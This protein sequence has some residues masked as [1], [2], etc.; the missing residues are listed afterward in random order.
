MR[1][2]RAILIEGGAT[3]SLAAS[4][5]L[6][7]NPARAAIQPPDFPFPGGNGQ[8]PLTKDF[9]Q[10]G[11]MVLQRSR[12]PLLE[13][14]FADFDQDV[15]TPNDKFFVRWHWSDIPTDIDAKS[16]RL[17]VRGQVEHELS[18]SLPDLLQFKPVEIAAVNQCSGNSR[19]FFEPRVPG[20]QWGNGAMGNAR[21]TGV[22]LKDVLDKAG[23]KAGAVAVRFGGLDK[24][25]VDDAPPFKKS[26]SIDHA[27]QPEILIAYAMN[28]RALPLLNGY[29]IRLVVPGWYSTYWIKMLSDIEVLDGPDDNYWM[30]TAYLIPDTPHADI[31]PG[32]AG[33]AMVPINRMSSR[34]FITNLSPGARLKAGARAKLRGLAMG[35]DSGVAK[36]EVSTDGGQSWQVAKLGRD[37]GAYSF[38][39]WNAE[40]VMGRAGEA[41]LAVRCTNMAGEV[42]PDVSNWNPS[43]FMRNVIERTPVTL[44]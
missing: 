42:Q 10:K 24:P 7:A 28:G 39:Q 4:M 32:Q 40:L 36:V 20:A 21:W 25:P 26:L 12:P 23:I 41:S 30:K 33:V 22:R 1:S 6:T 14:P 31:K 13:T 37:E 38:R 43:G 44:V 35:G 9:P 19:G 15:F 8:R 3:L 27:R 34:S 17:A 11:T 16:Y 29:P 2:R 18:V 5:A